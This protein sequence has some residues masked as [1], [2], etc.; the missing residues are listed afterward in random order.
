MKLQNIETLITQVRSIA[1][2]LV[3]AVVITLIAGCAAVDNIKER[4]KEAV[5]G[6]PVPGKHLTKKVGIV[7]FANKT[8]IPVK[9]FEENFYDFLYGRISKECSDIHFVKPDD[10]NYPDYLAKLSEQTSG[11]IDNLNLAK[12]GRHFG[13]NAVVT[14][15]IV[16]IS[17]SVEEKGILWFKQKFWMRAT[18]IKSKVKN[19]I[20]NR[21]LPISKSTQ[22]L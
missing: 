14:G 12:A 19:R 7:L 17:G 22:L 5:I 4:T 2:I 6:I 9:A 20:S 1:L 15:S 18:F 16:D 8:P 21:W 13:L 10:T 3:S 11:R